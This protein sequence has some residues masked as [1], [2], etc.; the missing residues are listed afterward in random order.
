M[1]VER[2]FCAIQVG[3]SGYGAGFGDQE[4]GDNQEAC[5][6]PSFQVPLLLVCCVRT[7]HLP[8][9]HATLFSYFKP[10]AKRAEQTYIDDSTDVSE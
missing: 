7:A 5:S 9:S 1:A 8:A 2:R 4:N 10:N 6:S 3:R